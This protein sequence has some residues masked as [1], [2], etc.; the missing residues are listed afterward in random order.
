MSTAIS[1]SGAVA[2]DV[3]LLI[4]RQR[5]AIGPAKAAVYPC[6][7]AFEMILLKRNEKRP[8]RRLPNRSGVCG[9]TMNN[10]SELREGSRRLDLLW[11]MMTDAERI[12]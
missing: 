1:Q 5:V 9:R 11:P 3:R 8:F 12:G 6:E 10:A 2:R 4:H 7:D